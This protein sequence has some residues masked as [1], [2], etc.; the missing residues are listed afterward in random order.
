MVAI[1]DKTFDE[2]DMQ[3][4][5]NRNLHARVIRRLARAGARVIV[6]DVQFTRGERGSGCGHAL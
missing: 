1:E 5:F 4:P 3:W 6:Y 2:L